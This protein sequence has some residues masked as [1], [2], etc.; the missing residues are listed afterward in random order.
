[1]Q[2]MQQRMEAAGTPGEGHKFLNN[3]VGNW[4]IKTQ[5]W[6]GP[7]APPMEGQ[8][9]AEVKW[10]L[11]GRFVEDRTTGTM[12]GQPMTGLG[13]TGY[14]NLKKRYTASWTDNHS[15]ALLTMEGNLDPS[16]R[17]LTM[18]GQLDDAMTGEMGKH[19]K[20]VLRLVDP[21]THVF[22][23]HDLHIPSGETKVMEMTYRRKK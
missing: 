22:E 4:D 21:D 3:F 19:V 6:M 11:G 2:Q 1:M 16:G 9:T 23:I 14:D 12:M 10:V 20:Y 7:G 5:M 18:F 8:A 13:Y 15:T 17:I